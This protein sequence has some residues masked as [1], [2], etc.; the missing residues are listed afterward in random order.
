MHWIALIIYLFDRHR[1]FRTYCV[2]CPITGVNCI[3]ITY[4]QLKRNNESMETIFEQWRRTSETILL[5]QNPVAADLVGVAY[6]CCLWK[7]NESWWC[8]IDGTWLFIITL[9]WTV[10]NWSSLETCTRSVRWLKL[11]AYLNTM[12]QLK[13]IWSTEPI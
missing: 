2:R 8:V 13:V 6:S 11:R 5:L 9:L 1:Y 4:G 7:I 12:N 3:D 10:T